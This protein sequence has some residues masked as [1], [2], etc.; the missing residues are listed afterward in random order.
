MFV[1]IG[2]VQGGVGRCGSVH[3]PDVFNSLEDPQI[4]DFVQGIIGPSALG[5]EDPQIASRTTDLEDWVILLIGGYDEGRRLS[6]VEVVHFGNTICVEPSELPFGLNGHVA[7][8]IS[9]EEVAICGGWDGNGNVLNGCH[10]YSFKTNIWTEA[11]FH[12][13]EER[14]YAS[15][16]L[17]DN[18]DM[19]VLGGQDADKTCHMP[20]CSTA[21]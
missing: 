6:E 18:R 9:S 1:Q 11:P 20:R 5:T 21:P 7:E 4:L 8:G 14:V 2:V 19:M 13:N 12:L 3:Y 15:S 16:V 10:I 17:L